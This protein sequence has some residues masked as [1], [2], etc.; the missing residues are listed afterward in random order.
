MK[1]IVIVYICHNIDTY[2]TIRERNI[3]PTP[4]IIFVG[5]GEITEEIEKD[6]HVFIARNQPINIENE[7][8]LLTFTAWYL[9]VM[10]NLL[11]NIDYFILL[12]W[13]VGLKQAYYSDIINLL[14]SEPDVI[15]L[16][17]S[18]GG[19]FLCDVNQNIINYFLNKKQITYDKNQR[20][21]ST[22]NHCIRRD[23]LIE[24]V[25]WY[26]PSCLEIKLLDYNR[27]SWYHER[28]FYVFLIGTKKKIFFSEKI[29]TPHLQGGS[30]MG[31]VNTNDPKFDITESLIL[32]YKNHPECPFLL[33]FIEYYILFKELLNIKPFYQGCGTYLFDG[34][35]YSYYE[36]MYEKQKLLF[37]VA[38]K[39]QR[40]LFIDGIY[41]GHTILI[42]LLANPKLNITCI[43]QGEG[44]LQYIVYLREKFPS[45]NIDYI[46]GVFSDI[47]SPIGQIFDS[48]HLDLSDGQ[49]ENLI[50]SL[51]TCCMQY[52]KNGGIASFVIDN[53]Y[54]CSQEVYTFMQGKQILEKRET[55]SDWNNFYF[56]MQCPKKYFLVYNDST[57]QSYLDDLI[58]SVKE[59][60]H[61]DIIEFKKEE[62]T[63]EFM[64][65]HS[66]I[67]S[68]SRGGGY[69][70]WKP[71]CIRET[72]KKLSDGDYLFYM[73]SKYK[74]KKPFV[75]LYSSVTEN[76]K[77]FLVWSNKPNE[78]INLLRAWCKMDVIQKYNMTE[79][80]F[81]RNA[82]DCWAGAIFL[83]KTEASIKLIEDWFQMCCCYENITDSP[84]IS[85]NHIDFQEH[86]HDQCL[87]SIALIQRNYN[88]V[89]LNLE[90]ILNVRYP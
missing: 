48:F 7:P 33:K 86:R 14:Y 40:M 8:K 45:A 76:K 39:S 67:L 35:T 24:F 19:G 10:N 11:Q 1:K 85:E 71:Y 47:F 87:L 79:P 81:E 78:S 9:I 37:D 90:H 5:N 20:W 52:V 21:F 51:T 72:L 74:M 12:E 46:N 80:I 16:N 26:Y 25:N 42:A 60:G 82:M 49:G 28:L 31:I 62:I 69:W 13:D 66:S 59:T 36:R 84:S 53:F 89:Y 4:Y 64:E 70:L 88:P 75:S 50:K 57:H 3:R 29:I 55:K 18:D 32:A 54:R 27:L 73:D 34:Q 17:I 30:H 41:M 68:C 38:Q 2:K 61:F 44:N 65:Q 56:K 6:P 77:D 58:N 15:G 22:T 83:K 23:I 63:A 43:E